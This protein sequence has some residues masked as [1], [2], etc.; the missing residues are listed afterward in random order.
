MTLWVDLEGVLLSEVSQAEK[1]RRHRASLPVRVGSG[2]KRTR[3]TEQEVAAWSAEPGV[4]GRWSGGTNSL[5]RF[6][7]WGERDHTMTS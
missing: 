6:Q 2:A 4:G 5:R 1:D 7:V 3:L